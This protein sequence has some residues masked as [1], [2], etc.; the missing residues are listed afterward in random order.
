M[1]ASPRPFH[2]RSLVHS[3]LVLPGT[4]QRSCVTRYDGAIVRNGSCRAIGERVRSIRRSSKDGTRDCSR[5]LRATVCS[6]DPPSAVCF[7]TSGRGATVAHVLWEHEAVGSNPTAPTRIGRR[8][9]VA[10]GGALSRA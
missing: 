6:P 9:L 10:G 3:R 5:F 1:I 8:R 4:A 2:E 7:A